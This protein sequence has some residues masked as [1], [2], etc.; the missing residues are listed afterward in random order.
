MALNI[1]P[2]D[3]R[4]PG[5]SNNQGVRGAVANA[6]ALR[7]STNNQS[8]A[9]TARLNRTPPKANAAPSVS[10]NVAVGLIS[11]LNKQEADLVKAGTFTVANNY[12]IEFAPAALGDA[13]VTKGGKP[14]KAKTPMQHSKNPADKVNPK[15]NSADYDVRTF[16]ITAGT[17]IVT[18]LDSILKNSSYITDQANVII[19]EVTQET[20]PQKPL[21]D[22]AWYKI[23]VVTT[24]IAF[25]PLRR[26]YA[27]NI[28]YVI[29]AYG[30]NDM[31]SEFYPE[32]R[33]RGRHKSYKYWFTGQN[34]Q[35]TR[36]EQEFNK[37]YAVTITNPSTLVKTKLATN[38]RESPTVVY[39]AAV[40]SSSS[41]GAD[42]K[43]NSIGASAAD[44]LY[45]PTDI[46]KTRIGIVGDPAWL[47]QGEAATGISSLDFNFNPFNPDGGINFDAQE[48]IFD[49][50]WNPGVDYDKNTGLADPNV[51][52]DPQAIYTYKA[53]NVV[54]TFSRGKFEQELV[55]VL[56]QF[57]NPADKTAV[58]GSVA[59]PTKQTTA[60]T[61]RLASAGNKNATAGPT[62]KQIREAEVLKINEAATEAYNQSNEFS[63]IDP[64]EN[65]VQLRSVQP[66]V[67]SVPDVNTEINAD[68][69]EAQVFIDISKAPPQRLTPEAVAAETNNLAARYPPPAGTPQPTT[70]AT[71]AVTPAPGPFGNNTGRIG[72]DGRPMRTLADARRD[73]AARRERNQLMAKDE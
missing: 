6:E 2:L 65:S 20:K 49:L 23:S 7:P 22:L 13:L 72:P 8:A 5:G 40:G 66:M 33:L 56:V 1:T 25:D 48:I 53:S 42:G 17:P 70:P 27:Y 26:D 11:A 15:S 45:S 3:S 19:D 18:V 63:G 16:S 35:V 58:A 39:Q 12:S 31:Q 24:P 41:Q 34:T 9:E 73:A 37:L 4:R 47:Q 43:T 51:S 28:K 60:E 59:K 57:P 14:N 10:K 21:G 44:F 36:F 55:G 29:S 64:L 50:Q 69:P 54:S 38:H 52:K 46:A 67:P 71:P 68:D 62:A 30:I 32:G 61:A